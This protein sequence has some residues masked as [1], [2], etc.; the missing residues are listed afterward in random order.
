MISPLT[1]YAV[2]TLI[3]S[4]WSKISS[5]VIAIEVKPF[6]REEKSAATASNQPHLRGRLL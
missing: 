3:V 2:H 6:I 4:K 1:S 5:F